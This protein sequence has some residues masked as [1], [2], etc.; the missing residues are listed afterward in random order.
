LADQKF[1]SVGGPGDVA[2]KQ[3]YTNPEKFY[4]V[5]LGGR[6]MNIRA[7]RDNRRMFVVNYLSNAVQTVDLEK[8]AVVQTIRLGGSS[9]PS[10]ARQGEAVFRDARRSLDQ[11]YSCASCHYDGGTNA[12]AMDTRNDGSD[13]T[14][15][16]VTALYEATATAPWTWHGWQQD[17]HAAMKK[18]LADT[19]LGPEPTDDDVRA[20]VAYLDELR[21]PPNPHAAAAAKDATLRAAVDRGRSLFNGTKAGCANCHS[22]PHFTDGEIHDV[23][24]GAETDK[25]EGFNTP[26]LV[27]VFRKVRLLHDG[28]AKSLEAVL[29]G[30]HNPAKVTGNGELTADELQDLLAYL[31][32]L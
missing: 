19:M 30:D 1:M 23:G 13:R 17:L 11:W 27:G 2:D 9:T 21:P 14:F 32:T 10:L 15:K 20:M 29:T 6:P 5:P 22:G 7:S 16:T 18:S 31:R 24:L 26:S 4:R 28:R 8:R 12:V 3:V 25:Y